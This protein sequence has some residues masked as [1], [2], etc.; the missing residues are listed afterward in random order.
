MQTHFIYHQ[1]PGHGWIQVPLTHPVIVEIYPK[2]TGYSYVD[3]HSVYL[4]EDCDA[5]LF[6]DRLKAHGLTPT[7]E[8]SHTNQDSPIRNKRPFRG[9]WSTGKY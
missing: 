2:I 3:E 4:E 1:D 8:R 6:D 5:S 7:Y 9:P